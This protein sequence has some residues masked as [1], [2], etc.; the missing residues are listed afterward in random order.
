[1]VFPRVN[2]RQSAAALA[3]PS[4][5][6]PG[7]SEPPAAARIGSRVSVSGRA[8][9]TETEWDMCFENGKEKM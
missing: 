9:I 6:H 7:K 1:M 5:L 8:S 4:P 3:T 2:Q